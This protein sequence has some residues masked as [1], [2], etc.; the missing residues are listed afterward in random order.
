MTQVNEPMPDDRARVLAAATALTQG[1]ESLCEEVKTLRE[2]TAAIRKHGK[3]S[4]TMIVIVA[5]SVLLDFILSVGLAW[6][7]YRA[8]KASDEAHAAAVKAEANAISQYEDCVLTN[9]IRARQVELWTIVLDTVGERLPEGQHLKGEVRRV[10]V[11]QDCET[12]R[13]NGGR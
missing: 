6:A 7:V 12:L 1:M 4:R 8:E 9:G 10:F 2:E 3:R 5:L 13:R 11:Q